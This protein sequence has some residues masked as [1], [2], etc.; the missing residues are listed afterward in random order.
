MRLDYKILWIEDDSA[1]RSSITPSIKRHIMDKGFNPN[2]E[3]PDKLTLDINETSYKDFDLMLIDYNLKSIFKDNGDALIQKIRK[4]K[5]FTNIVF[6]SSDIEKLTREI[7]DKKLN[8]VYIFERRQLDLDKID[9]LYELIDFFLEKE[10]DTN[11]LRGIAMSEVSDFD[12]KIW[13]IIKAHETDI[14]LELAS[15]VKQSKLQKYK[16]Y[17]DRDENKI[18]SDVEKKGT[19]ILDSYHM[20]KFLCDKILDK[21]TTC[22]DIEKCKHHYHL[23]ILK[24]RNEL[25]HCRTIM[26]TEEQINFRKDLIKFRGIFNKL[27]ELS[28]PKL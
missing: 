21:L 18:W 7:K 19:A 4:H 2:I 13:N 17:K 24:K 14:K 22:P 23:D 6:Y 20:H 9:D 10:M 27:E 16:E 25:A 12:A 11:S 28:C 8:G 3:A 5:I 15:A 26:S 1:W